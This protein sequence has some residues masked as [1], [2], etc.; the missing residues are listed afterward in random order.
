[1]MEAREI[2]RLQRR[3]VHG[4]KDTP[5][6]HAFWVRHAM[7]RQKRAQAVQSIRREARH[8]TVTMLR[9]YRDGEVMHCTSCDVT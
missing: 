8:N 9:T 3:F 6:S 5:H 1:M 2:R 4:A 7:E